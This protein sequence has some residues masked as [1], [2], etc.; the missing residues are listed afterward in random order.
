[1]ALVLKSCITEECDG[2]RY[3]DKTRDYDATSNPN[4][5]G[6][7][8]GVTGPSD[9]DTYTLSW[10]DA[11]VDPNG[12]P[13]TAVIDLLANVPAQSPDQDY[14]WPTFTLSELG[15]SAITDGIAYF[16]VV[17]VKDG[18]EYRADFEALL[19]KG[20]YEQLKPKGAKWRPGGCQKPGCIP[21]L[22]LITAFMVVQ[23]GWAC[24]P[25]QAKDII[26]WIKANL[27]AICC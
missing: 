13:P 19:V 10:W 26:K 3:T 12:N 9:F 25:A 16:E 27:N 5:Y 20:L 7:E 14:D 22:D 6:P 4:G 21:A 24:D 2:L 23:C 17:G 11:S 8:N 1:M 18:D 15:V